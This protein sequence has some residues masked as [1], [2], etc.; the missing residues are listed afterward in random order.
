[1]ESEQKRVMKSKICPL[2]SIAEETTEHCLFTCDWA[3]CVWI[4]CGLSYIGNIQ[5]ITTFDSWLSHVVHSL[6]GSRNDREYVLTYIAY[7]CWLIWKGRCSAV[8]G[9]KGI[10]I[11]STV[12]IVEF[13]VGKW[14][15]CHDKVRCVMQ[16]IKKC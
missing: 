16:K 5:Q 9:E 10:D 2:C 7:T 3:R 12:R 14:V 8:Y 13:L 1:M 11:L 4:G 6:D 15:K